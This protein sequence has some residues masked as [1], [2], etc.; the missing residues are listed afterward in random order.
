MAPGFGEDVAAG[1]LAAHHVDGGGDVDGHQG[2]VDDRAH[3]CPDRGGSNAGPRQESVDHHGAELADR[4]GRHL[5]RSSVSGNGVFLPGRDP[6]PSRPG[7]PAWLVVLGVAIAAHATI[8]QLMYGGFF[9]NIDAP[10]AQV[11]GGAEFMYHG[12]TLPSY[13]W[14][15]PW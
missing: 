4:G 15:P 13:C 10:V 14:P 6:A 12:G 2:D 11:Q 5:A 3:P 1:E 9:I 8:S 7:V